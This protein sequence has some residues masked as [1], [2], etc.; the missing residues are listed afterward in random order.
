MIAIEEMAQVLGR[1]IAAISYVMNPDTVVLG[2]GIAE[3]EEYLKPLIE[4][5]H[6][7]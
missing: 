2:G 5:Y 1:G 6:S 3:Q 7:E 4:T